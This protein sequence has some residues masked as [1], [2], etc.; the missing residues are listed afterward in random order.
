MRLISELISFVL[1]FVGVLLIVMVRVCDPKDNY[2]FMFMFV[3]GWVVLGIAG[4]IL[5][6]LSNQKK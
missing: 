4:I 6:I 5:A 2:T 1:L 3:S